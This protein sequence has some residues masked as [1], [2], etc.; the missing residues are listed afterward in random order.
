MKKNSII[1]LILALLAGFALTSCDTTSDIEYEVS[2]NCYVSG[3]TLGSLNRTMHTTSSTGADSTYVVSVS[4]SNYPMYIDQISNRIY[5]ADSLPVGTDITKT[6]FSSLS[7]SGSVSIK[8]LTENKDTLFAT[9]DSTDFSSPRIITAY[10][11]DGTLKRDYIMEVRVHQEE[12]DSCVWQRIAQSAQN[13]IAPFVESRALCV[14][15]ELYVFGRLNDG[16]TRL[17]QTSTAAPAFDHSVQIA[18]T[19]GKALDVRSVQHFKGRFYALADGQVV[20]TA[21]AGEAWAETATAT[22]FNAL[23]GISSDSLYAIGDG[24]VF[25]SADGINW[26]AG[27]VDTEDELPTA[28]IASTLQPMLTD[29]NYENLILVGQKDDQV[30]VWKRNIDLTGEFAYPWM[31]L[32]QTEELGIY[33]C[34]QLSHNNLVAYDG[35]TMLA[36]VQADGTVA[37]F[38]TSRDNGRT[39]IPEEMPRP[40][41]SGVT[42]LCIVADSSNY[43]WMICSGT[44][45]VHKGRIN[46]LGWNDE[47]S[48]FEK[49]APQH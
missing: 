42:A 7:A 40:E 26:V 19:S 28:N 13:A 39:W 15:N 6:V 30:S 46:R 31:Y 49:I 3:V 36:G 5:N 34:P 43:V 32:P 18:T 25:A 8:T 48:R 11:T 47:Q 41:A 33:G 21:T 9:T 24:R 14:D 2:R 4:G 45:E 22:S 44:G 23:A 1:A 10:S 17:V 37:P 12:A 27:T 29:E 38:Y 16:T 20:Q 35:A